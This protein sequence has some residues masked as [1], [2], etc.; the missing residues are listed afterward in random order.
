MAGD[1]KDDHHLIISFFLWHVFFT[2]L[3]L[4]FKN[5]STWFC[6]KGQIYQIEE[7]G[8]Q[9]THN[10]F[11]LLD[12]WCLMLS[13]HLSEHLP[14]KNVFF[15]ASPEKGGGAFF[16]H[17]TVLYILTSLKNWN[18][19]FIFAYGQGRGG[20]PP[21]PPYG[22][23]DRKKTVFLRLPLVDYVMSE[24]LYVCSCGA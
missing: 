11:R 13:V 5:D 24:T 6:S 23:P 7:G 19:I 15:Q 9:H 1:N 14:Q 16:H 17:V 22:Q 21:H 2:F 10:S 4:R 20:W 12:K 3:V 18:K 8:L